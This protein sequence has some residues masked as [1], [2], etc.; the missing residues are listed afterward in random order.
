MGT[1][2]ALMIG[3]G[4]V[5]ARVVISINRRVNE[6]AERLARLEGPES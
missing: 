5:Y 6:H 3:V 1:L 2:A 4:V